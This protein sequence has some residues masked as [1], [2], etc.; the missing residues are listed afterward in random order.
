MERYSTTKRV[1]SGLI[2]ALALILSPAAP[3]AAQYGGVTGLFVSV[4]SDAPKQADFS[5]LG[6]PGGSEVV[7]YFP[8]TA[9]TTSDPV[10]NQTVPGRIV[11]VTTSVIDTNSLLNGSFTFPGVQFPRDLASGVY[12]VSSRCGALDLSVTVRID[13][14]CSIT[15]VP[16]PDG[17]GSGLTFVPGN[18][19]TFLPFTGREASRFVSLGAGL[20]AAGIAATSWSRRQRA[21]ERL[22]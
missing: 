10:A 6:C 11:G 22:N 15:V 8:D 17:S 20:L 18:T 16:V 13:T 19:G 2:I 1:I 4:S 5:G 9:P 21:F 7:L 3:V 14:D 12:E